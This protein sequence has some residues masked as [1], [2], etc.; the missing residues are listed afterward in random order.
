MQQIMTSTIATTSPFVLVTDLDG[1]LIPLKDSAENTEALNILAD[2]ISDKN[3]KFVYATGRHYASVLEAMKQYELPKPDWIIC[4]VGTSIYIKDDSGYTPFK[5]YQEYLST[6]TQKLPRERIEE[7]LSHI[8]GL[9]AQDS[10]HQGLFKIS[11]YCRITLLEQLIHQVNG[12]LK[13]LN[14][15]YHCMGS[16]DPFENRGLLDILPTSVDKSHAIDWLTTHANFS[17]EEVVYAGDSG[18]DYAALCA[19][20]SILVGNASDGLAEQVIKS[21]AH[22]AAKTFYHAKGF[23][24]SGVVEGCKHY[25]LIR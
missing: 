22:S 3:I 20:K 14:L 17:S 23:A 12:K 15:P 9:N 18:N 2:N 16:I 4:D 7:L 13:Q 21:K 10:E 8:A 19:F 24:T 6:R 25:G 1:T 11:Y 5:H